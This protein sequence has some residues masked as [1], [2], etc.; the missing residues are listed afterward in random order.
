M[1]V[2]SNWL[3]SLGEEA[4]L[5]WCTKSTIISNKIKEVKDTEEIKNPVYICRDLFSFG[6]SHDIITAS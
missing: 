3:L 5:V 6:L 1:Y 4:W 2:V